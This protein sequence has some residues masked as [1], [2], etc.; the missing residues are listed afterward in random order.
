M[1]RS[2][3]VSDLEFLVS[4]PFQYNHLGQRAS[5]A[6]AGLSQIIPNYTFGDFGNDFISPVYQ[7]CQNAMDDIF[8][9]YN[10]YNDPSSYSDKY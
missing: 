3:R 7:G 6:G 9:I 2:F 10:Y 4:R 5:I 1:P 8:S